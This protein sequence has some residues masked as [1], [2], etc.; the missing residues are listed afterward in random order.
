MH[1]PDACDVK[2][3][4]HRNNSYGTY[5]ND[6]LTAFFQTIDAMST[7]FNVLGVLIAEHLINNLD[8]EKCAPVIKAVVR[9]FKQYM[10]LKH[11]FC[12][13]RPLPVGFGGG[14]YK[15]DRKVVDYMTAGNRD[16]CVDFWT[17]RA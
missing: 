9:D 7:F 3:C 16:S 6:L 12:G 5:N 14:S 4:I 11:R 17:V 2:H 8:S 10:D 15:Y 13:Q 1:S